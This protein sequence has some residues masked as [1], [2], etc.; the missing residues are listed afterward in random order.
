MQVTVTV[1]LKQ[2]ILDPESQAILQAVHQLGES[3]VQTLMQKRQF[4]L[5]VM[6]HDAQEAL[7]VGQRLGRDLLAN[8]VMQRFEVAVKE[9]QD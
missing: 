6:T 3:Q 1:F 5:D 2:G 7:A 8:P 4:I 9:K